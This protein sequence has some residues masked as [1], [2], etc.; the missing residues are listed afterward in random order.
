SPEGVGADDEHPAHPVTL[1]SFLVCETEVTQ[2]HYKEVVGTSPSRCGADGEGCGD[3]Y[4]VN[5]VSW[6]DACAYM[7]ELTERENAARAADQPALTACYV[8]SGDTW[9]WRDPACTGYRLPTEAEWEYVARAG[10][11]TAY[12]FGDDPAA[13]GE[14]AWFSDNGGLYAHPVGKKLPNP[15]G[16]VDI[17]GNLWEW[18]WDWFGP[19]SN[20]PSYMPQGPG[21]GEDR[22]LRGGSFYNTARNLRSAFRDWIRPALRNWDVGFR[23]VR[24]SPSSVDP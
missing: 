8:P 14:H 24:S 18:C 19:Y 4:P 22:V 3:D 20:K 13:L 12:S 9:E 17:H 1:P 15:W 10:T 6:N 2:A 5:Q 11:T 16:L 23:C 21:S 7:N